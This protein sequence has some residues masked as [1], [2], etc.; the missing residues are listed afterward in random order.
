[1]TAH[2]GN[3]KAGLPHRHLFIIYNIISIVY[4][5]EKSL[6]NIEITIGTENWLSN[7][8]LHTIFT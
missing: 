7:G 2:E 6:Q 8:S 3:N 5:R 1:M 4:A